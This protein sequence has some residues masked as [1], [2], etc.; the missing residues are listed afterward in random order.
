MKQL[1]YQTYYRHDS[2]KQCSNTGCYIPVDE[3]AVESEKRFR[4]YADSI[5]ADYFIYDK[6]PFEKYP[7]P[8]W[9]RFHGIIKCIEEEYDEICYADADILPSL[10]SLG[11]SI[12]NYDGVA[13]Q[14]EREDGSKHSWHVNAGVFKL[15]RAEC[16]KMRSQLFLKPH[17]RHLMNTGKN[18]D[19]FNN[20]YKKG[21]GKK[22]AFLDPQWNMTRQYHRGH[23]GGYWAHYIGHQK[24]GNGNQ[25]GCM[26]K[27]PIYNED[28]S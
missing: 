27:C 20:M 9:A 4:V 2:N 10:R 17:I 14:T 21:V 26:K 11:I 25:F 23:T 8:A 22:P 5:N 6:P 3:L 24:V 13:K 19:P 7:Q 1:I 18:Q 28:W 12:F 16:W 15:T